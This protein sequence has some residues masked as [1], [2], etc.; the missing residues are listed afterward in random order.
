MINIQFTEE[1]KQALHYERCHHPHPKVQRKMEVLWLKSQG[2]NHTKIAQLTGMT[3]N[4]VTNQIKEY[5]AGG[6]ERLKQIQYHPR[7]S[8]LNKH[9]Q[10][11]EQDFK[12]RPPR[13]KRRWA[14]SRN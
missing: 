11:I 1:E 12:Q 8:E 4:T 3:L 7:G 5:Q 10:S 14:V 9:I 6:I 13:S 2:E